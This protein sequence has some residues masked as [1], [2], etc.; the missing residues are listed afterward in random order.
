MANTVQ[1]YLSICTI[2]IGP[3]QLESSNGISL[4]TNWRQRN[5]W[6]KNVRRSRKEFPEKDPDSVVRD[7]LSMIGSAHE[8]PAIPGNISE[9]GKDFLRCCF[10]RNP[11]RRSTASEILD[12]KYVMAFKEE[13]ERKG[14][15]GEEVLNP[16]RFSLPLSST[17]EARTSLYLWSILHPVPF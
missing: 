4:S 3:R 1:Q 16:E 11:A 13:G 12:N 8:S 6:K 15:E 5:R 17:Y 9:E 10:A 7:L 14:S 2:P